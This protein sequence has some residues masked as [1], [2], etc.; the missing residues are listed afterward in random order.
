MY[1]LRGSNSNHYA[2]SEAMLEFW[3]V[4]FV[5]LKNAREEDYGGKGKGLQAKG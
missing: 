2:R 3:P 4:T 1:L 5:A